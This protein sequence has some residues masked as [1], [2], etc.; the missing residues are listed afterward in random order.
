MKQFLEE[1]NSAMKLDWKHHL[2][3]IQKIH[4]ILPFFSI[5]IILH[6]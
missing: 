5:I 1:F 3:N 6:V 2:P 4:Y